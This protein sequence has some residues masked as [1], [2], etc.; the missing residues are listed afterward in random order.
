MRLRFWAGEEHQPIGHLKDT[1]DVCPLRIAGLLKTA[2][3]RAKWAG[4]VYKGLNETYRQ[5]ECYS[6]TSIISQAILIQYAVQ[7]VYKISQSTRVCSKQ[8]LSPTRL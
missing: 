5:I 1:T 7:I 2:T 8:G 6:P 4:C 3:R